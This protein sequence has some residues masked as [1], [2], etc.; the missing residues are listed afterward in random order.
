MKR[1]CLIESGDI[2]RIM[3]ISDKPD[4]TIPYDTPFIVIR[5]LETFTRTDKTLLVALVDDMLRVFMIEHEFER[6]ELIT[7]YDEAF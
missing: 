2:A 3:L 5:I 7:S 4:S 6:L 1:K